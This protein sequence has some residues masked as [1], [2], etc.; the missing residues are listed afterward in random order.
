MKFN[1]FKFLAAALILA[2][3]VS[4]CGKSEKKIKLAFVSN[5]SSPFWTEAATGCKD[6][7]KELGNVDV[8]FR[9]PSTGTPAEQQQILD[10][11]LAKGVDGIA[12]SPIDP[13]NE[14]DF[15]NKIAD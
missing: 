7:A 11:L 8:D 13:A 14:T 3:V 2:L 1:Q 5:N 4:G 12:A 6:A 10:D 9:I 15:L